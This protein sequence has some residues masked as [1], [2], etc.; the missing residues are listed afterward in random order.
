MTYMCNKVDIGLV[1]YSYFPFLAN[2]NNVIFK[3]NIKQMNSLYSN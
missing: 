1:L 3:D 2:G